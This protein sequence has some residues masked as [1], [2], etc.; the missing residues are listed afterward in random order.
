M[1]AKKDGLQLLIVFAPAEDTSKPLIASAIITRIVI[2]PGQGERAP[3]CWY[4]DLKPFG[5]GKKRFK[6]DLKTEKTG[7]PLP[8]GF[9]RSYAICLLP[10]FLSNI[11]S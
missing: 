11:G 9:I 7:Q 5:A 4:S 3:L 6:T 10:K 8:T 1:A 2:A